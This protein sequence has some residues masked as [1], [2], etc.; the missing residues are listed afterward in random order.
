MLRAVRAAL[1]WRQCEQPSME[2]TVMRP[3]VF[4]VECCCYSEM[5]VHV[6]YGLSTITRKTTQRSSRQPLA[7]SRC[8]LDVRG[9]FGRMFDY[10]G[11]ENTSLAVEGWSILRQGRRSSVQQFW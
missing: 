6:A 4:R 3:I 8:Q 10:V 5:C 1:S 9:L 7:R 2:K 11:T